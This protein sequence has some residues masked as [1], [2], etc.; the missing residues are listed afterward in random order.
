MDREKII[1]ITGEIKD[2][3]LNY[4]D[5]LENYIAENKVQLAA[6]IYPLIPPEITSAFG[7]ESVKLPEPVI[8]GE[9]KLFSEKPLYKAVILPEDEMPCCHLN[10]SD[11]PVHRVKYPG[12]YGEDAAVQL[13]NETAA[14]LHSLFGINLKNIDI[15]E[16]Q[17]KTMIFENLRR[18]VRS[19][20]SL[21]RE[22]KEIITPEDMDLIFEASSVFPPD[23]ALKLIS[24]LLEELHNFKPQQK[25]YKAKAL[26]YGARKIPAYIIDFIENSG[27]DIE[28]DDTCRGRR[29]FDISLN[30]ESEYLFYELLDA[31]SYRPMSPCIR[32]V[33]ERY[34]LLYKLLRNYGINLLI[35]YK[36]DLCGITSGA[37]NYLRIKCMRD[38]IDPLVINRE[39]YK[40]M[41]E[42]YAGRL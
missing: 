29:L 40:E 2:A 18:S 14:M 16:L 19:I 39:N 1:S 26:I 9:K 24:P 41:I 17:K 12:G 31:Y 37:V 15:S 21:C 30:A 5:I 27:I 33:A 42:N 36:D 34:E 6:Y 10:F 8:T 22:R 3:V 11:T 38:G 32:T 4:R 35:F 25:E 28:E 7:I 20:T 23:S 13:H